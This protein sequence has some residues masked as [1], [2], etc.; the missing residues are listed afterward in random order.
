MVL[1]STGPLTEM[2]TKNKDGRSVRLTNL[3]S[4]CADC[5]EIGEPQTLE[6]FRECP[7]QL[8]LIACNMG[9]IL[10]EDVYCRMILLHEWHFD[11]LLEMNE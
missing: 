5:L 10:Q 4:S 7:G 3:P 11:R 6:N 2:S 9:R 1:T 8:Y